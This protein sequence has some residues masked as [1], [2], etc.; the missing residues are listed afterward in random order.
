MKYIIKVIMKKI[1]IIIAV[2]LENWIWKNWDLAWKISA[3]LQ[4]FKRITTTV[5]N[6][7]NMNMVVMWRKTWESIP[8]KFK[9][10]PWRINVVLT[11]NKD[12]TDKWCISFGSIDDIINEFDEMKNI[13]NIFIIWWASI[14]N[15]VLNNSLLDKIYITRIE[16]NFDCDVFIDKIPANFILESCSELY[17]ENWIKFKFEVY[18]KRD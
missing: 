1:N 4:Y 15:Q 17:E 11:R 2:D 13:E 5:E 16:K 18:K 7:D 8:E 9:P 6:T 14:Y 3:D 10:L 12:F